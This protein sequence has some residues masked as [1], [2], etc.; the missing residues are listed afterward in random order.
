MPRSTL[1]LLLVLAFLVAACASKSYPPSPDGASGASAT[2]TSALAPPDAELRASGATAAVQSS[3]WVSTYPYGSATGGSSTA[4]APAIGATAIPAAEST[5]TGAD[6]GA[7][8]ASVASRSSTAA[9]AATSSPALGEET[10]PTLTGWIK[11]EATPKQHK[12]D[13]ED[14]YRYA[15]AQVDHDLRI[16]SDRSA[17]SVDSDFGTGFTDLTAR[18]NLYEHRQRR[19]ELIHDCMEGKGYERT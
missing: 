7:G 12:A 14:C 2:A 10:L 11:A 9:S 4:P 15:W 8:A 16:E 5:D 17:A 19:T 1:P 13:I 3:T 6:T 18:M